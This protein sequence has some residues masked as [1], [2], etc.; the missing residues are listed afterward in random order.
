MN[1]AAIRPLLYPLLAGGVHV[2]ELPTGNTRADVVHITDQ[3]MH[4]YEIKGDNDTLKRVPNQLR[5]YAQ[6]YDLVTFVITQKHVAGVLALVPEWV[7]I[8]VASEQGLSSLRP[9]KLHEQVRRR[10]LAFLLLAEEVKAFLKDRGEKGLSRLRNFELGS[11]LAGAEHIPL[12]ELSAFVR[13]RLIERMPQRL[14]RRQN[15]KVQRDQSAASQ[16]EQ[17]EKYRAMLERMANE[18][19]EWYEENKSYLEAELK[20]M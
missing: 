11:W 4:G 1:D 15:L 10:N 5:C 7:G 20:R 14:A 17:K 18:E 19:P 9:A 13:R 6:A 16:R 12:P 8:Y 2:D 3:F